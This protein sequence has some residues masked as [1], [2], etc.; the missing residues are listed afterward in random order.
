MKKNS[1]GPLKKNLKKLNK[2][3]RPPKIQHKTTIYIQLTLF[4]VYIECNFNFYLIIAL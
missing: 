4:K 1:P 3:V 2:N